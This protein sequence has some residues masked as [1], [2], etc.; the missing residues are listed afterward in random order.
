MRRFLDVL[1]EQGSL[2]TPGRMVWTPPNLADLS[3]RV[4]TRPDFG[5]G[6]FIDKLIRQTRGAPPAVI[7]LAGEALF[8]FHLKD[9]ET[10]PE[11]KR[12]EIER[13][14]AGMPDPPA[15]PDELATALQ[16]GVA[17]YGRGKL[18]KWSHFTYLLRFASRWLELGREACTKPGSTCAVRC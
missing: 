14:L 5:E 8:V 12:L 18:H 7:Q 11:T 13:V 9:A 10:P 16:S 4:V 2:L 3:D 17:R 6:S 15:I 1:D